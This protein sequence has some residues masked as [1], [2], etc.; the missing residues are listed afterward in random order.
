MHIPNKN[1]LMRFHDIL[2]ILP[3]LPVDGYPLVSYLGYPVFYQA[4]YNLY[5][6]SSAPTKSYILG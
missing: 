2:F 5:L 3:S 1:V 4:I 6:S